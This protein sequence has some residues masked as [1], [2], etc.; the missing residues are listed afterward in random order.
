MSCPDRHVGWHIDDVYIGAI[1]RANVLLN[2]TW[3]LSHVTQKATWKFTHVG[4]GEEQALNPK[5]FC[6]TCALDEEHV[7]SWTQLSTFHRF[8]E[9]TRV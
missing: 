2:A 1:K 9:L 4:P 8:G 6:A 3:I 7:P 5:Q